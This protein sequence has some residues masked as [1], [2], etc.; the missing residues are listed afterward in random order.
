[1][2]SDYIDEYI[3]LGFFFENQKAGTDKQRANFSE[4]LFADY[5]D[6]IR[7]R[8][9]DAGIS[10]G[11]E[12]RSIMAVLARMSAGN[13]TTAQAAAGVAAYRKFLGV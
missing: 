9:Q 2:D 6:E 12:A 13:D 11:K 7:T 4:T 8:A 5:D 3:L 1:M 10:V